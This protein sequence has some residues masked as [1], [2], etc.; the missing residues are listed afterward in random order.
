MNLN[1]FLRVE[2]EREIIHRR[3]VTIEYELLVKEFMYGKA[4]H[5]IMK[6]MSGHNPFDDE[7]DPLKEAMSDTTKVTKT[8]QLATGLE[9]KNF[10]MLNDV[11]VKTSIWS[12]SNPDPYWQG[13]C[14]R[15]KLT[16]DVAVF[17]V[18]S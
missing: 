3:T 18:G 8:L 10:L 15:I 14:A 13:L 12:V 7:V 11:E 9:L 17:S 1:E 4:L 16:A 5:E 6:M 2:P